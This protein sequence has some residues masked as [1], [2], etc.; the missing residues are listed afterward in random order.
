MSQLHPGDLHPSD[1]LKQFVAAVVCAALICPAAPL[2]AQSSAA[3]TPSHP[4]SSKK[5]AESARKPYR[6][7]QLSG[8][9]RI[10]H[11]LNRFTFGPRPGDLEAVRAMGLDN[12]FNQQLHPGTLDQ[13]DLQAR[14][15]KYPAMQED[16]QLILYRLPSNAI[17]RQV[18]DGKA[19]MPQN[20]ALKAIY[21]D[22]LARVE[23]RRQD[24]ALKNQQQAA[25][26]NP[27]MSNQ[28][29]SPGMSMDAANNSMTSATTSSGATPSVDGNQMN[30]AAAP[31]PPPFDPALAARILA[32]PPNQRI[33][34]LVNMDQQGF[35]SFRKALK[36]PQRAA[37]L[38]DLTPLQKEYVAALENPERVV[39]EE[40]FAQR[41]TR[42]IYSSA[43]LQEVMT[44]FWMNHFN[45]YLRKNE[46]TPYYLVSYERD[47]IRPR[48]LGKFEDLLEATAHSPAMM[49]YLD[50][51][52]SIGPD[53]PAAERA[54]V[55]AGPQS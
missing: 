37:M 3:S 50:N 45:V 31:E 32:M 49:I 15:E 30:M 48:A 40:L 46:A 22:E 34:E 2:V 10:L 35:D 43:Q 12:W 24:K 27:A 16:P 42:D 25:A 20:V 26:A 4:A 54:K 9:D 28:T 39:A 7:T 47:V 5:A 23:Q 1:R 13:T 33:S 53:S 36:G 44:D 18:A 41:L 51:A 29:M 6:S 17:I 55:A 52:Q 14:L 21:S 11:A 19:P 8:D 38:A